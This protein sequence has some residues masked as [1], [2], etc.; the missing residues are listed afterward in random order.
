MLH[1]KMPCGLIVE[2]SVQ[3]KLL[4]SANIGKYIGGGIA[5][6]VIFLA[7]GIAIGVYVG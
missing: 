4:F 6:A 5:G 3:T 2:F 7:I 1:Y